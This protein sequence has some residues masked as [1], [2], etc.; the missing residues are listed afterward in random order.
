VRE[1]DIDRA[2]RIATLRNDQRVREQRE[3]QAVRAALMAGG[4]SAPQATP[5]R[6]YHNSYRWAD[7][8]LTRGTN[9]RFWG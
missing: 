2:E 1:E 3:R 7:D 9:V 6:P 5:L 8:I 4:F